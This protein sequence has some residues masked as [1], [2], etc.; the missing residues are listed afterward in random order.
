MDSDFHSFNIVDMVWIFRIREANKRITEYGL[1]P[2]QALS[3]G[4]PS[5]Q[6]D[7]MSWVRYSWRA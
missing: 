5:G 3:E 1:P 2:N 7:G 6:A 4:V